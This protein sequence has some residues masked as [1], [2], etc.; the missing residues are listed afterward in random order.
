MELA[1]SP[2]PL[3]PGRY[4][5]TGFS[6]AITFEVDGPWRAVQLYTGFFD[7]QQ[8]VDT[9]D[10][11]AVQFAKPSALY[12][13]DGAAV[14]LTDP[15]LAAAILGANPGLTVLETS[16][17]RIGGLDGFQVTVENAGTPNAQVMRVPPGPL[18]ILEGRRLW[19][20]LFDTPDGILA[21]M[22]GGSVAAWDAALTTAEPILESVEIGS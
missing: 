13:A 19:I 2:G 7:I 22:V 4:T 18:S 5:R 3:G 16:A 10:V 8:D 15:G 20:A 17:S 11:I 12:G 6:P 9:P 14:E 1:N 21:I